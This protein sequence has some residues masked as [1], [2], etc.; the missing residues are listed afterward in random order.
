VGT[1][2]GFGKG[3]GKVASSRQAPKVGYWSP[4]SDIG[5]LTEYTATL[6]KKVSLVHDDESSIS[7]PMLDAQHAPRNDVVK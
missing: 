5:A 1:T 3:K 7:E 2:L 4:S 6:E